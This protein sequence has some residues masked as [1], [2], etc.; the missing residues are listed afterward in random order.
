M[1]G[2]GYALSKGVHIRADF[3]Y[4]NWPARRQGMVDAALYVLFYFPSLI[5]FAWVSYDYAADA[6]IRGER[7]MD[8]AWMAPLAPLRTAMPGGGRASPSSRAFPSS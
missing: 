8:T 5:F 6:W 1:L 7:S 2:A 4:R 3:L